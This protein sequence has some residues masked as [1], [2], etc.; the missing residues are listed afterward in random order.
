MSCAKVT[1]EAC[2]VSVHFLFSS[3][4]EARDPAAGQPLISFFG[5]KAKETILS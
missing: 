2:H 1:P 5:Q 3:A 4:S